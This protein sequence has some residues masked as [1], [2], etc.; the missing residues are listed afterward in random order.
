MNF[1]VRDRD[2]GRHAVG[3][4]VGKRD[5]ERREQRR[6]ARIPGIRRRTHFRLAYFD[7]HRGELIA[8]GGKRLF[9]VRAARADIHALRAVDDKGDNV[10]KA[11]PRFLDDQRIGKSQDDDAERDRAHDRAVRLPVKREA[12]DRERNSAEH[13]QQPERQM[14]RK[15]D[16][17]GGHIRGSYLPK[18]S[19]RAG[20]CTWSVL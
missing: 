11:L 8:N 10:G 6:T 2:G 16:S 4:R 18:R 1:A 17:V 14:G 9:R 7:I 3:R 19:N 13:D 12:Q 5:I 15:T 20:T